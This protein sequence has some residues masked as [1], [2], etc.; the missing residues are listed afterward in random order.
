MRS[1]CRVCRSAAQ[2]TLQQLPDVTLTID[3][4]LSAAAAAIAAAA[5]DKAA[6]KEPPQG[7]DGLQNGLPQLGR[8]HLPLLAIPTQAAGMTRH[9]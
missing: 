8:P 5:A 6:A 3:S 1:F 9:M 7:G 4:G 2:A